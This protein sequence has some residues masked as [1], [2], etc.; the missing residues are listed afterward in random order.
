M[1]VAYNG[2][3]CVLSKVS[4]IIVAIRKSDAHIVTRRISEMRLNSFPRDLIACV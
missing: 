3:V 4:I 2:D 1:T